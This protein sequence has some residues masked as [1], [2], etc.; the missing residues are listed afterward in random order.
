MAT[1]FEQSVVCPILVSRVAS[2]ETLSW[3]IDRAGDH[4][5]SLGK[6]HLVSERKA[7]AARRDVLILQDDCFDFDRA[8]TSARFLDLLRTFFAGFS[9][10]QLQ[11]NTDP[12][13]L[14]HSPLLPEYSTTCRDAAPDGKQKKRRLFQT[15][16]RFFHRIHGSPATAH[17]NFPCRIAM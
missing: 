17:N 10:D 5:G 1:P 9:A 7:I 4:S 6:S 13:A 16:S 14:D 3:L 15:L 2:I 8:L 11:R 12:N